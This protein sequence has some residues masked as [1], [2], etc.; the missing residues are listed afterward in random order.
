M[1]TKSQAEKVLKARYT[2]GYVARS[3]S[4]L[5]GEVTVRAY[6]AP[7]AAFCLPE[8]VA[9]AKAPFA[10]EAWDRLVKLLK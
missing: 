4:P 1:A 3:T 10:P 9:S 2:D 8:V 6:R 7:Q 5:T